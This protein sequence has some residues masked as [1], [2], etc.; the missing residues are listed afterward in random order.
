MSKSN[1]PTSVEVGEL[2]YEVVAVPNLNDGEQWGLSEYGDGRISINTDTP[3]VFQRMIMLHEILHTCFF[4]AGTHLDS[5]T[6]EMVI[7]QLTP[8]LFGV[9][10]NNPD[11]VKYLT[12][13]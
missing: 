9:L 12:G 7:Q 11:L 8:S 6:E 3:D 4:N 2:T 10:R 13:G 5:E 1:I